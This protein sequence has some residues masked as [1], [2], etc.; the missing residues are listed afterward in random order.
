MKPS[1]GQERHSRGDG[2]RPPGA[3]DS[4]VPVCYRKDDGRARLVRPWNIKDQSA[5]SCQP[6]A[7]WDRFNIPSDGWADA[8]CTIGGSF[9]CRDDE[10][11]TELETGVVGPTGPQGPTG[12]AGPAGPAGPPGPAGP[13][14]RDGDGFIFRGEWDANASYQQRDVVTKDGSSY[15]AGSA[16]T[17]IDPTLPDG[18]WAVFAARGTTG[19]GAGTAWS[20]DFMFATGTIADVPDLS[21]SVMATAATAGITVSTDGGVQVNSAVAGMYVTVDIFLFCDV[22][23]SSTTDAMTKLVARRR[24]FAANAVAQQTV[25]NWSF[26]AVDLQPPGGP[27]TYRVAAQ[28]VANNGANA[29][30]SGSPTIEP[31]LRGSLSAVVINK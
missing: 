5:P 21:L 23:A 26:S 10:H 31:W 15:V 7:P 1:S 18:A 28:L 27:Y 3:F 22:P 4:I 12:A 8:A 19:Q 16:S 9:D 24:I 25:T 2:A 30:V 11:Y 17:G 29:V 6:P 14:G 13:V 20:E